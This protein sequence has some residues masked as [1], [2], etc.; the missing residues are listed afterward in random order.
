MKLSNSLSS[1]CGLIYFIFYN[2]ENYD[3]YLESFFCKYEYFVYQLFQL[4]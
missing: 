3:D 1:V 4:I 2:N